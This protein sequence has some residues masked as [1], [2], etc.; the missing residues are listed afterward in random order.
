M[1]P[2]F[3][4][5][6]LALAAVV[7]GLAGMA[8]GEPAE[9]EA[10]HGAPTDAKLT[11]VIDNV[12]T[13]QGLMAVTIYREKGFLKKGGSVKVWRDTARAGEQ[14]MCLF[15][16][17]PGIYGIGVYQDLDSDHKIDHTLLGPT[18]PWG[19]SNNPKALFALPRFSQVRF[20]AGEGNTT[21]HVRL[22]YP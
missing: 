1:T 3:L 18:E 15:L 11:V 10:C 4:R 7:S 21:V 17:S 16:P 20:Q 9:A 5:R 13:S 19:F 8:Q 22:N 6:A 12:K 14:T 2:R